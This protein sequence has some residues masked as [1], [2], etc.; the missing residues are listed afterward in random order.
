[1]PVTE[2]ASL[3]FSTK[4][5]FPFDGQVPDGD[6]KIIKEI[7]EDINNISFMKVFIRLWFLTF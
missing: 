5:F 4:G 7:N 3:L 2:N 6:K 1:M